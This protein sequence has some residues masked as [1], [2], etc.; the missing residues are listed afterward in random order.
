[1]YKTRPSLGTEGKA[2]HT[3]FTVKWG[4]QKCIEN[5]QWAR[6][7][8]R[9]LWG[10]PDR[11]AAQIQGWWW[12]HLIRFAFYKDCCSVAKSCPTLRNSMNYSMPRL[13]C[14]SRSPGICSKSCPLSWCCYPTISSSVTPFS[15]SLQSFT[16]S[17]SFPMSWLF[18]SGG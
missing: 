3:E 11:E 12:R 5:Y 7:S 4:T 14:S 8:L 10:S 16:A 15:S 18:T 6:Q 2:V 1:M 13:P 17:G 9:M